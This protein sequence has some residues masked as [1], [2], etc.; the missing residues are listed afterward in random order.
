MKSIHHLAG[1]LLVGALVPLIPSAAVAQDARQ[2]SVREAAGRR[3]QGRARP[4]AESTSDARVPAGTI[5]VLV[6]DEADR[7]IPDAPVRIGVMRQGGDREAHNGRT[8]E[9]GMF[10]QTG[11]AT[12]NGQAYRVTLDHRTARYGTTPFRLD[13]EHGQFAR[14]RRLP[15]TEDTRALIMTVGQMMLEY[16]SDRVKVTEQAQLANLGADTVL[17]GEVPMPL[18]PGFTAFQSQE[19]MSDQRIVPDDEGF[20]LRGSLPPGTVTLTW[21]YDIPL[22]GADLILDRPLPFRTYRYRVISDASPEMTLNVE[23]FPTAERRESQGRRVLMTTIERE[24]DDA[25]LRSIRLAVTGIPSAGPLRYV[26]VGAML[27]L[28]LLGFF[29]VTRTESRASSLARARGERRDALLAEAKELQELFD[30]GEVGPKYHARRMGELTDEIASLLRLE[31]SGDA[32]TK[33]EPLDRAGV[34]VGIFGTIYVCGLYACFISM[35]YF[36]VSPPLWYFVFLLLFPIAMLKLGVKKQLRSVAA[37]GREAQQA[38]AA[39][40]A[41][42]S[43]RKNK[44]KK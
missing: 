17:L 23:G 19:V 18:P 22:E 24:P 37:A 3:A 2:E 5:R 27:M 6:V 28:L 12:G 1:V 41:A 7:P 29:L 43:R 26:A 35:Q 36:D 16:K 33:S 9:R 21:A 34:A 20:T 40:A 39:E 25:E 38:E 30:H 44:S 32:E 11:L 31:E 13:L 8:D 15:V 4:V 14:V 10:E 42:E